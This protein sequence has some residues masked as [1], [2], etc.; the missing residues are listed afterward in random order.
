MINNDNQSKEYFIPME[1]TNETI[2]DFGI[3]PEKVVY[4]KIGNRSVKAIMIPVTSKAQ[5][6]EYMRPLWADAKREERSKRCT[7]SN[8][9]GK[10]KRCTDDCGKCERLHEGSV[11]SLDE[12]Q[13]DGFEETYPEK[14]IADI[15]VEMIFIEQLTKILDELD[16]DSRRICELIKEGLSDRQMASEFN[17]PKSTFNDKKRRMLAKLH[18]LLDVLR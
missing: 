9:K 12:F 17:L 8:G 15:V 1:V 14:D 3:D 6:D 10:L 11:L 5:Y 16:P 13:K 4:T 2:R 7:V 18:K